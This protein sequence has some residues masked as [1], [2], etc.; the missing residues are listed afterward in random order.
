MTKLENGALTDALGLNP[1]QVSGISPIVNSMGVYPNISY[2]LLTLQPYMLSY[3][4]NSYGFIQQAVSAPIDDAFRGGVAINTKTLDADEIDLLKKTMDENG[5]WAEIKNA[6]RWGRLFGGSVLIANTEQNAERPLSERALKDKRLKFLSADRW[7]AVCENPELTPQ[8]S[9]FIYHGQKIDKSRVFPFLGKIPPYYV[10]M[11]LQGWGESMLECVLPQLLTLLKAQNVIFEL[12][13][14]SKIDI[15]KIDG[16]AQTLM[17]PDGA[18]A[19]K[20]RVDI[21]AANKN[22]KSMLTMDAKDNYEQKQINWGGIPELSKEIRVNICSALRMP[23]VKIWGVGEGGFSNG[24]D[25]LELYNSLVE[26]EIREQA[27][28]IISWVV[29]LR[30]MQLFGRKPEDLDIQWKNLRS[31]PEEQEQNVK[32]QKLDNLLKIMDRRL[33]TPEGFWELADKLEVLPE[34]DDKKKNLAKE[35]EDFYDEQDFYSKGANR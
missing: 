19:V 30:C 6:I 10:R 35:V 17:T 5:D 11:R 25:K 8:G 2:M 32:T 28:R 33:L 16:L 29:N 9:D 15:L 7:E 18:K 12:L 20:Q 31:M 3:A 34:L 13:D 22:F 1:D 14:E 26:S 27:C 4:Y 21:A 23:E 24:E